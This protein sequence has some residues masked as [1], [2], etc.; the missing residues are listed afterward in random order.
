MIILGVRGVGRLVEGINYGFCL[1]PCAVDTQGKRAGIGSFDR[2]VSVDCG[3]SVL[4]YTRQTKE[5]SKITK[6]GA[7]ERVAPIY[8][9]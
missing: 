4:L 1:L 2:Y 5:R 8:S 3:V 9:W 6:R 7:R